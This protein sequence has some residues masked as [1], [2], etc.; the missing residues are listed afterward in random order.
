MATL[1]NISSLAVVKYGIARDEL[2]GPLIKELRTMEGLLKSELTGDF[3]HYDM[4]LK[5]AC[6]LNIDWDAGEWRFSSSISGRGMEIPQQQTVKIRAGGRQCLGLAG[7]QLF[8]FDGRKISIDDFRIDLDERRI[9][10]YGICSS[11]KNSDGRVFKST[12]CYPKFHNIEVMKMNSEVIEENGKIKRER[13][14][15]RGSNV[16][17][18]L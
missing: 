15:S 11:F 6:N 16:W 9:T 1:R 10:F 7:G 14:F 8:L 12:I 5:K 4:P 3:F 13:I 18:G 17:T 2:P